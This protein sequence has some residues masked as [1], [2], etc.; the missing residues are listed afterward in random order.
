MIC[1]Y[2]RT[3]NAENDHRCRKCQRRLVNYTPSFSSGSYPVSRDATARKYEVVA[4]SEPVSAPVAVLERDSEFTTF[5]GGRLSGGILEA[6]ASSFP[7]QRRLFGTENSKL[8]SI[9]GGETSARTAA[10]RKRSTNPKRQQQPET[11]DQGVLDF[12]GLPK[13]EFRQ[14]G[15][16]VRS[17]L[18]CDYRVASVMHRALAAMV[19]VC[20]ILFSI[21]LF[22]G[23][24]VYGGGEFD[25]GPTENKILFGSLLVILPLFYQLFWAF[26]GAETLGAQYLR[27]RLT[28]FDG[29]SPKA[30]ARVHRVLS[31]VLSIFAS[32]IGLLWVFLDE[33][34]LSWH[35]HI[36]GTFLT[37]DQTNPLPTGVMSSSNASSA[38][39]G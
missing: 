11:F 39:A 12:F 35:D 3:T 38:W 1:E 7:V 22:A 16:E 19:D 21:A 18:Y 34:T 32:G 24:F 20:M 2:C 29:R 8:V 33:E 14:L 36:S 23:I 13:L 4:E 15:Q 10:P 17:S 5:A 9:D 30:Q 6:S 27:L 28:D 37:A 26:A 31:N 25:F